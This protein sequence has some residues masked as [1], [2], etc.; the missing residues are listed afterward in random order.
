[1]IRKE[2]REGELTDD[3]GEGEGAALPRRRTAAWMIAVTAGVLLLVGAIMAYRPVAARYWLRE[4]RKGNDGA[5]AELVSLGRPAMAVLLNYIESC[6]LE[7]I[8]RTV[9]QNVSSYGEAYKRGPFWTA[10]EAVSGMP[11]AEAEIVRRMDRARDH[12]E[13]R[14]R[15]WIVLTKIDSVRAR[16]GVRE[17]LR[18]GNLHFDGWDPYE[19][20]DAVERALA[21]LALSQ[22]ENGSWRG[23]T[24]G[25]DGASDLRVTSV[26][27]LSY[28]GVG[29]TERHG[30]YRSRVRAAQDWLIAGQGSEGQFS[31]VSFCDHALAAVALSE[32]WVM[33]KNAR[34]KASVEAALKWTLARQ[35]S[36]GGWADTTDGKP[37]GLVTYLCVMQIRSAKAGGIPSDLKALLKARTFVG[38]MLTAEPIADRDLAGAAAAWMFLGEG[39]RNRESRVACNRLLN[40]AASVLKDPLASWLAGLCLFLVGGEEWKKWDV[41]MKKHLFDTVNR[42]GPDVGGWPPRSAQARRLG[43]LGTTALR[44]MNLQLYYS[45]RPIYV[46]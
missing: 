45:Y 18:E 23:V 7:E 16:D 26:A 9:D 1:M 24:A 3:K 15:L 42:S 4:L 32:S 30:K 25:D 17:A 43:P 5:T 13:V 38:K 22:E 40:R 28:L 34:S 14:A 33:S 2:C 11:G 39:R 27:L 44:A 10:A 8:D 20:L 29:Y 35:H 6:D 37:D 21:F 19:G 41:L 46:K 36:S 12:P 31:K